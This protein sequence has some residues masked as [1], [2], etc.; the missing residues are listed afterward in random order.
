MGR[1]MK[2]CTIIMLHVAKSLNGIVGHKL[3]GM[4]TIARLRERLSHELLESVNKLLVKFEHYKMK[5]FMSMLRIAMMQSTTPF[6]CIAL[7]NLR[8]GLE[9]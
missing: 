8:D 6:R 9:M 3:A 4:E 2:F 7:D 5:M 1:M